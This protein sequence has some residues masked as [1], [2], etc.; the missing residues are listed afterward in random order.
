M[1]MTS[2]GGKKIVN[3]KFAHTADVEKGVLKDVLILLLMEN[4]SVSRVY[5]KALRRGAVE[6]VENPLRE[7]AFT[8]P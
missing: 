7:T 5:H 2:A 1:Q 4:P 6:S 3:R 8:H